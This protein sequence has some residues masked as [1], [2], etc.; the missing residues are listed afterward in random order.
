MVWI[1]YDFDFAN[2]TNPNTLSICGG[3]Y[4]VKP[5]QI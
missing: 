5:D 3:A 4:V 1:I 2:K